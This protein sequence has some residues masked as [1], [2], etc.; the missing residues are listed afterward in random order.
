MALKCPECKARGYIK[1]T[2]TCEDNQL[3][4]RYVCSRKTCKVRWSTTELIVH[5]DVDG[6][7]QPGRKPLR[8]VMTDKIREEVRGDIRKELRDLLGMR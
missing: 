5:V 1:D 2:R 7:P 4:R 8:K 3:R 6:K